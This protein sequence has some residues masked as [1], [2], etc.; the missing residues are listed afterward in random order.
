MFPSP[1]RVSPSRPLIADILWRQ[2]RRRHRHRSRVIRMDYMFRGRGKEELEEKQH[3]EWEGKIE[4]STQSWEVMS[5]FSASVT[6][7]KHS[8]SVSCRVTDSIRL[9]CNLPPISIH[10]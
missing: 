3:R 7:A 10:L 6:V 4:L 5:L 1:S 9:F 2:R 8:F